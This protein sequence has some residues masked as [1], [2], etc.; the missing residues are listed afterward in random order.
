MDLQL[1]GKKALVTG[2]GGLIGSGVALGVGV[3]GGGGV[4]TGSM[5]SQRW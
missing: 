1:T 2:S 4:I 5:P 3:G